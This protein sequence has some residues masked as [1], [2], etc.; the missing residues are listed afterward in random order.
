[1]SNIHANNFHIRWTKVDLPC[2]DL[3]SLDSQ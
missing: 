1:M 3:P 2:L